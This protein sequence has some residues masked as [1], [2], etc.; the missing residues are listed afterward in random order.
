M[1]VPLDAPFLLLVVAAAEDKKRD[2][3]DPAAVV[4]TEHILDTHFSFTSHIEFN[5]SYVEVVFYVTERR[6]VPC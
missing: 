4:I 3:Y 6:T 2:N 5:I 1:S